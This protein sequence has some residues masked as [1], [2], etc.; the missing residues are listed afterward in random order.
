[1]ILV[2]VVVVIFGGVYY[3]IDKI[4]MVFK[5]VLE[6]FIVLVKGNDVDKVKKYVNDG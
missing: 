5:V 6:K 3:G 2:I 1:M 4:M